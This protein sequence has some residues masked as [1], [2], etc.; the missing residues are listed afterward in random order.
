[1]SGAPRSGHGLVR[2]LRRG[3]SIVGQ[4]ISANGDIVASESKDAAS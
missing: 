3:G 4:V 1:M 2:G